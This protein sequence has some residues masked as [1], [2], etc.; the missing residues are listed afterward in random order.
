MFPTLLE[1]LD[2]AD[3][4][5]ANTPGRS[6]APALRGKSIEWD[7]TVFFEYIDTRVIQTRDWK[8]TKR[9]LASPNELYNLTQDPGETHN[10]ATDPDHRAIMQQLDTQ[11]TEFFDRFADPRFDIWHGGTAKAT[12]FYGGRNNRFSDHFPDWTPPVIEKATPFR[13]ADTP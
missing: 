9:F 10:L 2:L 12:L 4:Q 3:L 6:F 7:D 13:D 5:I 8:Y 1:Y 11:L